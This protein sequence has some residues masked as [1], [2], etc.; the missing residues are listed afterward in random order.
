MPIPAQGMVSLHFLE[1]TMVQVKTFFTDA[2]WQRR[3]HHLLLD[4][5]KEPEQAQ[6]L[7]QKMDENPDLRQGLWDVYCTAVE[8]LNLAQK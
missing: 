1:I 2:E 5:A 7:I 8:T 4:M 6:R 3:Q